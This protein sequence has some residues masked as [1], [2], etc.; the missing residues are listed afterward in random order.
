MVV[1]LFAGGG[2]SEVEGLVPFLVENFP[3]YNFERKTPIKS[4]PGPKVERT[5]GHGHA[6]LAK[7]KTTGPKR[8]WGDGYGHTGPGLAKQIKERLKS[9]LERGQLGDLILVIDDLDCHDSARQE[10]MFLKAVTSV[11]GAVKIPYQHVGFASPE[12]EAWI[13]ADWGNTIAHHPDFKECQ[14]DMRDWLSRNGVGF[15]NPESFS[16]LNRNKTSCDSKLSNMMIE[17]SQEKGCKQ[18]YRK[19]IHTP[20]LIKKINPDTVRSKCLHFKKLYNYLLEFCD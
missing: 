16:Q 7:S 13:I 6:D 12:I 14:A 15:D 8:D 5:G 11:A 1:W 18:R 10:A 20:E 3:G 4:K 9:S 19:G 17:S 2:K